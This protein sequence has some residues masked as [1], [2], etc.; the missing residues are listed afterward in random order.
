MPR[1]LLS[2]SLFTQKSGYIAVPTYTLNCIETSTAIAILKDYYPNI[3]QLL[4][5]LTISNINS[6]L[7][8]LASQK[9]CCRLNHFLFYF[10]HFSF[11][12][13]TYHDYSTNHITFTKNRTKGFLFIF[14]CIAICYV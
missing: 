13:A 4:L 5:F 14:R 11:S 3:P 1:S 2:S 7:L 8:H 12:F 6:L 10:S 9:T